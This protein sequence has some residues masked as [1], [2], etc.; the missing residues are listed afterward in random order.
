MCF[1]THAKLRKNIDETGLLSNI[2]HC[3]ETIVTEDTAVK[4]PQMVK[5]QTTADYQPKV[6][7]S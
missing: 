3:L 2:Y 5:R 4:S 7:R 1:R 6:A